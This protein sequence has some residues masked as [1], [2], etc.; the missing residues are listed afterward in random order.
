M[1]AR[2]D[3]FTT[4]RSS[5]LGFDGGADDVV[6][7]I[8]CGEGPTRG[9]AVCTQRHRFVFLGIEGLDDFRPEKA[10]GAHFGYFHEVVH[11]DGPE[12]R[13]STRLNS[14]HVAMS[15]ACTSRLFHYTTLFRS[16]LRW[17]C[18]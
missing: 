7:R 17:R 14:S 15:Y 2:R 8:L 6:E 16:W 3:S 4:R 12:D 5:D 11:A 1:R 10:G 9:L 13:K 18:G